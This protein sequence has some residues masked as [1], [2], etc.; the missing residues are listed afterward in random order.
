MRNKKILGLAISLILTAITSTSYARKIFPSDIVGRSLNFP[1]LGW[2]GHVGIA[3]TPM[4]DASGMST[5]ADLVGH[6]PVR[7]EQF[8]WYKE[9]SMRRLDKF[10]T[11]NQNYFP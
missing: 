1:G 3:T 2:L 5:P 10:Y 7:T 8:I 4:M 11:G 9:K 6:P